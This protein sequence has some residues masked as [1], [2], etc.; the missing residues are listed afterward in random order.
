MDGIFEDEPALP[1]G[2]DPGG[3]GEPSLPIEPDPLPP[4]EFWG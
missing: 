3:R 1:C 2:L 4:L